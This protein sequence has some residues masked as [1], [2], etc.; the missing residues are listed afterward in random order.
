MSRRLTLAALVHCAHRAGS[1]LLID[2]AA[3][4]LSLVMPK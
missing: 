4:T 1:H 2:D 3:G